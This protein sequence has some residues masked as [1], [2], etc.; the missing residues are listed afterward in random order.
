MRQGVSTASPA[1]SSL[2]GAQPAASEVGSG[3]LQLADC[4]QPSHCRAWGAL[5]RPHLR[6]LLEAHS[7]RTAHSGMQLYKA[8]STSHAEAMKASNSLF[9]GLS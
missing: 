8:S 4:T 9:P 6:R 7:L 3:S 2:Q 1:L 5:G